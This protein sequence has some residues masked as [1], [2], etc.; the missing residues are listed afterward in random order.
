MPK[1]VQELN[2]FNVGTMTTPDARDIPAEAA[3]YSLDLDS[4]VEDGLLRGVP[5]D[6]V[7]TTD[8]SAST[9]TMDAYITATIQRNATTRDVVYYKNSNN[10]V[11]MIQDFEGTPETITTYDN[12]A[13]GAITSSGDEVCMEVNNREVHIGAGSAST[14]VPKWL[15]WVDYGQFGAA[16]PT[17]PVF[18]DARLT[19]LDSFPQ[20]YKIIHKT[21][22]SVEYVFGITYQGTDL[23]RIKI[24]DDSVKRSVSS[25]KSTQGLALDDG[26][27]HLWLYDGEQGTEGTLYKLDITSGNDDMNIVQ[28]NQIVDSLDNILSNSDDTINGRITDL[29]DINDVLWFSVYYPTTIS[30]SS[31]SGAVKWLYKVTEPTE[32]GNITLSEITP[33][34]VGVA[35]SPG[36]SSTHGKWTAGDGTIANISLRT[37]KAPL[38]SV[39]GSTTRVACMVQE[40]N[41]AAAGNTSASRTVIGN[42]TGSGQTNGSSAH[43]G[44]VEGPTGE[45]MPSLNNFLVIADTSSVN[46]NPFF[47]TNGFGIAAL[48]D[49]DNS[50]TVGESVSLSNFTSLVNT[51]HRIMIA[52]KGSDGKTDMWNTLDMQGSTTGTAAGNVSDQGDYVATTIYAL[53]PRQGTS[54]GLDYTNSGAFSFDTANTNSTSARIYVSNGTDGGRIQYF[55][56]THATNNTSAHVVA[57]RSAVSLV[58]EA[59]TDEE[60]G[61]FLTTKRYFYSA[62]AVYDGYQESSLSHPVQILPEAQSNMSVTIN[63]RNINALSPRVS[64]VNLYRANTADITSNQP[65]GFFRLVKSFKLNA[66]FGST[67]DTFWESDSS[68]VYRQHTYNDNGSL[69]ASYD[70][71]NGISEVIDRTIVNYALSTQLNGH[72]VVGKCYHDQLPDADRYIFKSKPG[73]FDQFNW[74]T[75]FV[76]L[77]TIPVAIRAFQGRVYAWDENTT[78][79]INLDGMYIED[80][81]E[82]IGCIGHQAVKVT[83]YGMC[84]AD[85]NNI[86]L[87]DGKQP[88]AISEVIKDGDAVPRPSNLAGSSTASLDAS[89][90]AK[91]S[92]AGANKAAICVNF[93]PKRSS[94][95]IFWSHA[96]SSDP[97]RAYCWAYNVPRKRWDLW[98]VTTGSTSAYVRTTFLDTKGNLYY[99]DAT[100]CYKFQGGTTR[101][102]YEYM[103]KMLSMGKHTQPKKFHGW[104][105]RYS[106]STTSEPAAKYPLVYWSLQGGAVWTHG[107]HAGDFGET[108]NIQNSNTTYTHMQGKLRVANGGAVQA[109]EARD[110]KFF[111]K[112]NIEDDDTTVA[113]TE[114]ASLGV[115]FRPSR[116]AA[117]TVTY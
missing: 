44:I 14:D 110:I 39:T 80:I 6:A 20:F 63:I 114:V 92:A 54:K 96:T 105:L 77:P 72:H 109:Q 69:G 31:N 1:M 25:F 83:E 76:R 107:T 61:T 94:F 74:T 79:K 71:I 24:S 45:H 86:Y 104:E 111:I 15:G 89:W 19:P 102:R 10:T 53:L 18:T 5:A 87:H 26:G 32:S 56:W 21:I 42:N 75:D 98:S 90:D 36:T 116:K 35:E 27:D 58:P 41:Y 22:N 2:N 100:N 73:K 95:L 68:N 115:I 11:S 97:S 64:H 66:E 67:A 82:G 37:F 106:R 112:D 4:V 117:R 88:V 52:Y 50:N 9:T 34:W 16:A 70:A 17:S 33:N 59:E 108:S 101:K 30:K 51:A 103:T 62:T 38:T 48:D 81:Y 57:A 84:F 65:D 93:D 8:T 29:I 85:E 3:S 78:Y 12:S 13:S 99:S 7:Q 46:S 47:V 113:A 40:T 91:A 60:N 28:T 23:Y 55:T 43:Y 49:P